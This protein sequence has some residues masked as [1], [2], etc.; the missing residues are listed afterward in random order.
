LLNVLKQSNTFTDANWVK[1]NIT[2]TAG[3]ADPFGGTAATTL[4]ATGV[5]EI[6]QTA[7]DAG[8]PYTSGI[9][10]RRRTGSG[11]VSIRNAANTAWIP[12]SLTSAWQLLVNDGG[13]TTANWYLDLQIST[14]GDAVDVYGAIVS[15]GTLTASQILSEGGIPLTLAAAASNAGAGRCSW[16]VDTDD[17]LSLGSVPFQFTDDYFVCIGAACNNKASYPGVLDATGGTARMYLYFDASGVVVSNYKTDAAV[18]T[19]VQGPAFVDGAAGVISMYKQSGQ[20]CTGWNGVDGTPAAAPAGTYTIT[21][22]KFSNLLNGLVAPAVLIKG[23][24]SAADRLTLKRWV[25]SLTPAGPV[26]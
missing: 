17:S 18:D 23:Q 3:V 2:P 21:T 15:P 1:T 10:I 12:L 26:F 9:Y 8:K 20:V 24:V 4:T 11:T 19:Y 5:G 13:T 14:S 16:G 25:A 7:A 6:Y 22:A